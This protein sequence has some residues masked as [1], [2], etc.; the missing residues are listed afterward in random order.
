MSFRTALSGLNS[1]SADLGV[2][3]NNIANSSTTGFKSSRAEFADIY[4]A[5][6]IGTASNAIGSG[7]RLSSVAQQFAQGNVAFT[8]NA[9]DLA[10]NGQGFFRLSDNGTITYSRAGAFS[11]DRNGYIVNSA[12]QRL[13]AFQADALGNITGAI[14]DLQLSTSD[15][16]PKVSSAV[17]VGLNLNAAASVPLAPT[18]SSAIT[19]GGAQTLRTDGGGSPFTTANFTLVDAYGNSVSNASLR[20]TYSGAGNVWGAELLV[21]GASTTPA[22][23][24]GST[25][26]GI[27]I[28]TTTSITLNWD[29]DGAGGQ[30]TV[31]LTINTSGLTQLTGSGASDVTGTGNGSVQ[32][33][34]NPSDATSYNNSTSLT[35]YDSL[36]SS[37]LATM[38]YR[39]T[40]TPNTWE[41]YLYVDGTLVDGPDRLGFSTSGAL[42]SVNGAAVPPTT[43]TSPSFTPGG[44]GAAM[45][46]ALD[47]AASTQFGS[48][49]GVNSLTQDGYTTGRLSGVDIDSG[50]V[51]F[52]RYTNGQSRALGQVALANFSNAQGLRQ[53]GN[54][55]WAESFESGAALTGAPGTASLGVLQSGA[56]EGSNVDLTEQLV[57]M[58]TA[59][60]NFQA[61]AQVISALDTVTQAIINIR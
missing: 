50:G 22:T 51:V 47:Y 11:V 31:P 16:A 54:T 60:R 61:N 28:G 35:I 8:N 45:T 25:T 12:D 30:G 14:G 42:A 29:P 23:T 7:V 55:G 33:A 41:T 37:H 9:L 56:L 13:T 15:I 2:I 19:L 5:S 59:Q 1:A 38:Y 49:F 53:L 46:L 4:A 52:A 10:I 26:T 6:N 3:S 39:K 58:I 27:T 40:A 21:G 57:N 34:L 18:A 24:S 48:P 36:G 44:G 20:F 17:T 32:G 43:L